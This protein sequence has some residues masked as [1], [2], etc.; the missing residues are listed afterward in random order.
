MSFLWV[1]L[2]FRPHILSDISLATFAVNRAS[3][4]VGAATICKTGV[5]ESGG[6]VRMT[7]SSGYLASPAG[8][9]SGCGSP[10]CPWVL[11]PPRG[12]RFNLTFYNFVQ[13]DAHSQ[14]QQQASCW[15]QITLSPDSIFILV[16]APYSYDASGDIA[17]DLSTSSYVVNQYGRPQYTLI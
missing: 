5:C 3:N 8:S 14:Q 7:S 11:S 9:V 13:I 17:S 4:C 6:Y 10:S 2:Q 16:I 12:Q 1:Q 15:P